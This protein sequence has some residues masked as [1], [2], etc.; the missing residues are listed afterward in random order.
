MT[1]RTNLLTT[2]KPAPTAT[3]IRISVRGQFGEGY[4]STFCGN[5]QGA[6]LSVCSQ[7]NSSERRPKCP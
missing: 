3:L 2:L 5:A 6:A 7:V 1:T 4:R